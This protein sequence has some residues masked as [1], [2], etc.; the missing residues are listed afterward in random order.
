[1]K[2]AV[3][4]L[5]I[6]HL[7]WGSSGFYTRSSPQASRGNTLLSGATQ[8]KV[9][10]NNG[11]VRPLFA[12]R[13]H[14]ERQRIRVPKP[15]LVPLPLKDVPRAKVAPHPEKAKCSPLGQSCLIQ[16][17]CCE[18]CSTCHCR[19]FNAICFCRK[20]NSQCERK[21]QSTGKAQQSPKRSPRSTAEDEHD[22]SGCVGGVHS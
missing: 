18:P 2:L 6:L 17:G 5:C 8:S 16:S 1:M 19:F 14:Y 10:T 13:R 3:V 15:K 22:C 7:A 4:C 21:T 12:R 11:R 20:T 9:S